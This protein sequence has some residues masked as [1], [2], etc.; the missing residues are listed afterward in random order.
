ENGQVV[1]ARKGVITTCSPV[2][3]LTQLLPAGTLE[4]KLEARARD[5]PIRKTHATSLKINV[6]LK[7]HVSMER[8]EKWRGGDLDLRRHLAAWHTLKEQD[9]AWNSVVRGQ[10]PDPV[11]VSCS[12]V[13]S[14]VDPSQAPDG[15]STF[16]LWSGVIP[17]TPED[18]WEE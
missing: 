9:D 18:P 10:W 1:R 13:P 17:V 6:A 14:S 12:M 11:P 16:Y 4:P 5:I 15:Q 8:H 2:I 3:T 7:G